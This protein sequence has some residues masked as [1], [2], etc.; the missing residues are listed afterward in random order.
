MAEK[1]L[2]PTWHEGQVRCYLGEQ[3]SAYRAYAETLKSILTEASK[4]FAQDGIVTARAKSLA[5]FSEKAARNRDKYDDP[6][7]QLTDL[8]GARIIVNTQDQMNAICRFIRQ[9]F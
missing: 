9:E 8:C 1:P 5:S 3:S 2:D 6:C 7:H 4:L